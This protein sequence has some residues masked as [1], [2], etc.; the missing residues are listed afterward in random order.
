M[1]F[2]TPSLSFID[3]SNFVG[4]LS[5]RKFSQ[6]YCDSEFSTKGIFPY[7]L[8]SCIEEIRSCTSFPD[9]FKFKNNLNI[10]SA[11]DLEQ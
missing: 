6:N 9:Y 11:A 8:F 4:S 5:L 1:L 7:S 10:P 3:I 2:Q